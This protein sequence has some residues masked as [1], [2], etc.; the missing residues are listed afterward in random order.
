MKEI[1]KD[2][3]G[4]ETIFIISNMGRVFSKRTNKI[5]KQ[6]KV[7]SGYSVLSTRVE[8]VCKCFRIHRLVAMAF[9]DN[10]NDLPEVNHKDGN[11]NNNIVSNLEWVTGKENVQHAF[12]MGLNKAKKRIKNSGSKLTE[13]QVEFIIKNA[14]KNGGKYSSRE[15]G[16]MF[17]VHHT[18]IS[19]AARKFSYNE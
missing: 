6:G 8:G 19:K 7:K 12:K 5:L 1:W 9:I 11:K 2:V 14:K 10:L 18:N 3:V 16:E 4:Y 15:L 13:E 17:N